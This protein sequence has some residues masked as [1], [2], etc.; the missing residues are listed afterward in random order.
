[1]FGIAAKYVIPPSVYADWDRAI[2]R[3]HNGET[4]LEMSDEESDGHVK[5]KIQSINDLNDRDNL[6]SSPE[7]LD[8]SD[9]VAKAAHP[10]LSPRPAYKGAARK[11]FRNP[12]ILDDNSDGDPHT[13][14]PIIH[15]PLLTPPLDI[16]LRA[17]LESPTAQAT[18]HH[19]SKGKSKTTQKGRSRRISSRVTLSSSDS[20]VEINVDSQEDDVCDKGKRRRA[21]SIKATQDNGM[22]Q[23]SFV[24]RNSPNTL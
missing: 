16:S 10:R 23:S 3:A 6:S 24:Y 7:L 4:E 21:V 12:Y 1:M 19:L 5:K 15:S 17:D 8:F 11:P 2:Q 13:K 9:L 22:S 18:S 14:S 20:G